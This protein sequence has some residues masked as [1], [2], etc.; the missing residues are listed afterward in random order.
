MQ[1][2]R[3]QILIIKISKTSARVAFMEFLRINRQ[4]KRR[5]ALYL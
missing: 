3:K 4:D 5:I 1:V 2:L